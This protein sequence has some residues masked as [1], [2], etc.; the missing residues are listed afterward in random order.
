MAL[1]RPARMFRSRH[2]DWIVQRD[3]STDVWS[4][5]TSTGLRNHQSLADMGAARR[6]RV[7][8]RRNQPW[9][10]LPFASN[11]K[12]TFTTTTT[13]TK[14]A[15]KDQN[16][17]LPNEKILHYRWIY[18][19][20]KKEDDAKE[21]T[22]ADEYIFVFLHGLFGQGKNLSSLAQ[23]LLRD[24][25]AAHANETA[26]TG[27]G[28]KCFGLL[29]DLYGHGQ[30]SSKIV[31]D[32]TYDHVPIQD[33]LS[34][35]LGATISHCL[36]E[37][38]SLLSTAT[39]TKT[40]NS[41]IPKLILVGHSLGGRVALHYTVQVLT[42]TTPSSLLPH[43]VWLLD[44]VP[45]KPD[46]TV[47]QVL[48]AIESILNKKS[49]DLSRNDIRLLM[50]AYNDNSIPL[51]IVEWITS[52]WSITEQRFQFDI[53]VIRRIVNEL[54]SHTD[55]A[56]Q[57]E[58]NQS[59]GS[60]GKLTFWE[61]LN[62]ALSHQ[63]SRNNNYYHSHTTRI[64]IVQADQNRAWDDPTVQKPLQQ[65]IQQQQQ[66]S[67]SHHLSSTQLTHHVLVQSGHWVHVDN[68]PGLI[69]IMTSVPFESE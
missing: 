15:L 38:E 4:V 68:L 1:L 28:K 25:A 26:N 29:I 34:W 52:Q 58:Q 13:A 31:L 65:A 22:A 9:R 60:I 43:H 16:P 6:C 50:T 67:S 7:G 51:A 62:V 63:S 23:A 12:V 17:T 14:T 36:L 3:H 20:P 30:S 39:T 41:V 54:L 49:R 32:S 35:T 2:C 27:T 69:E 24:W 8:P 45:N 37:R 53:Q 57:H 19:T 47:V 21:D 11:T 56:N 66:L 61:Q 44:T 46:G 64:H 40:T 48:E 59:T 55:E 18:P 10:H 33:I 5:T 42:Q